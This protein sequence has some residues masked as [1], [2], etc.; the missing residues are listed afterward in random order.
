VPR[1]HQVFVGLD[2]PNFDLACLMRNYIRVRF[3]AF[4]IQTNSKEIQ[5]GAD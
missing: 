3:V 2:D 5:A 4:D 1:D